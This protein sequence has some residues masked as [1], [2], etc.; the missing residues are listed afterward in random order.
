[1][2]W[3]LRWTSQKALLQPTEE[4]VSQSQ[5][6]RLEDE[7]ETSIEMTIYINTSQLQHLT[8][9]SETGLE[10]NPSDSIRHQRQ[11][12]INS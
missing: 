2:R 3:D 1:M 7:N 5:D 4:G 10:S 11:E 6:N 12:L 9:K 8:F